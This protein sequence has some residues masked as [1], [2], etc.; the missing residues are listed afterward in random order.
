MNQPRPKPLYTWLPSLYFS[1]GLV[2]GVVMVVPVI[3]LKQFG[4]SNSLITFYTS[5][6]YLPWVLK[7]FWKPFLSTAGTYR[8]WIFAMQMLAGA[9]FGGVAYTLS[10][11]TRPH[12]ILFL[13]GMVSFACSIGNWATDNFYKQSM[14]KPP[15]IWACDAR[16][17][18][19]RLA[20]VFGQGFLIM[21]AGNLQVVFRN[22]LIY[23]WSLVFYALCA[24]TLL[25]ALLH[26]IALPHCEHRGKT[27]APHMPG[28]PLPA[29]K[30]RVALFGALLLLF[31]LPEGLLQKT[32]MLFMLDP[33]HKG[34][35]GLSPQEFGLIQGT[36][37]VFAL[38]I[39][40]LSGNAFFK[41]GNRRRRL[42]LAALLWNL[43]NVFYIVLSVL[44]AGNFMLLNLC[45]FAKQWG[46][47]FAF[48]GLMHIVNRLCGNS[49]HTMSRNVCKALM[50]LSL[51][52]AG[53]MS[54]SLQF[55]LGYPHF[56]CLIS[57]L[58]LISAMAFNQIRK[59]A[60]GK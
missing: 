14:E 55:K 4:M 13:L 23:S 31:Y 57:L 28:M 8:P 50:L 37:G 41:T 45:V 26:A 6:F 10:L 16:L 30:G 40:G 35:L 46:A 59:M 39:G 42:W 52:L 5:W 9:A 18:F 20:M 2:Y 60:Y 43:P 24:T 54:G 19:Y 51:M 33:A 36:I 27:S 44:P 21:L 12:T 15:H 32:A 25:L 38:I 34:G 56:F 3:L 49:A 48:I 17:L 11:P 53:M 22:D 7:P 1:K 58:G 47:G 29:Q